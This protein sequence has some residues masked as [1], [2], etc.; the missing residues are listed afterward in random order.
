MNTLKA[1]LFTAITLLSYLSLSAQTEPS[2]GTMRQKA[3]AGKQKQVETS[4]VQSLPFESVGP[5]VF[6]GRVVDLD[7]SPDDPSHFLVAYASGGVW[8]TE[9]NGTSFSPL[10]DQEAV[11]TIGDIAADWSQGI[12]WV[13]TGEVNSSRSSYA[14]NGVYR[15][16][17]GGQTWHHLGL[18][19]SHHIGRIVLHPSDTNTAW[20]AVLGH[21]YSENAERGVYKT[22]DGG[23]TW[24][25][26]L[27]TDARTGAVDLVADPSNPDLIYAA[28]W[29]RSRRAWNFEEAGPGSGIWRSDD[30][31]ETWNRLT[32]AGSGFPHHDQVG[33]IG[34]ACYNG[35]GGQRLYAVVDNYERRPSKEGEQ[36]EDDKLTKDDLRAMTDEAFLA[37]DTDR[38]DDF[39]SSNG[40]PETYDAEGVRKMVRN[41]TI[42][43]LALVE[44]LED[45]NSLLFDTPIFGAQV[46]RSDDSGT[47]WTLTNEAPLEG[48]FYTYGY[49]F[50]QI[51]I[52]PSNPDKV[53]IMG[54]PVLKSED[55]GSTFSS[56]N[57]ANVH[58]DHHALWVNPNRPGHLI[59]GN[60][61]GVNISY[62]DGQHWVHCN[63]PPV[64]Q[65]YT[66]A[67]DMAEPFNIYGGLQD[68]GVWKGPSTYKASARWQSEGHYPYTRLMGGDGMQVAIDT[69][70]NETVYTGYQFGNT[71]RINA[72]G[73]GRSVRITPVHTLG[74]RPLRWNWQTPI[75]LSIHNQDILYLGSQ[76]VHRSMDQGNTFTAISQDLTGGGKKGD[77]PFGTLTT[78]HES[79]LQFGLIYT[80]SDDGLI[81]LTEDGGANWHR[82]TGPWPEGLWVSRVQA[83][84]HLQDRL[85]VALNGYRQDDF[86]AWLYMSEDRGAT[87]IDLGKSLPAEPVNV[88]R[89]DPVN[90]DLLY[91]GTDHGA[92]VSLNGGKDFMPFAGGLPNVPVH[93]L[94][95]HPRDNKLVLATHGRSFY[96][97]DVTH[98]QRLDSAMIQKPVATFEIAETRYNASWGA[99]RF[100]WSSFQQPTLEIPFYVQRAGEV[101]IEVSPGAIDGRQTVIFSDTI[102]ASPGLQTYDYSLTISESGV[103]SFRKILKQTSG[104]ADLPD[105]SL[106][107]DGRVYLVPGEYVVT[108]RS[109]GGE[110]R[111]QFV[112]QP[113]RERRR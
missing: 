68:N 10:F 83:S 80:G 42:Q 72:N 55:G 9:N 93:D 7:V 109:G 38:I 51:R 52:S 97:A 104:G 3:H 8:K 21:L 98:L 75:H 47:T 95:V 41:G 100:D 85:F 13:G 69:R 48:V 57:G 4:L 16:S 31:G 54:V 61:G 111:Q 5:S 44:Y 26:V 112:I 67:L 25:R 96:M 15:S 46:Y 107:D 33:R 88:V 65:F 86:E 40:F 73:R 103:G 90:P 74:E 71:F 49:Y 78:I 22:S 56:I 28:M 91:V 29:E 79:P 94:M 30:G 105:L 45:A 11:I 77:V 12:I 82:L 64:G 76:K 19:E 59:L 23:Q 92:W 1:S 66:V 81:H 62:D 39:L 24:R 99:R 70:D 6:G 35:E 58:A 2:P 108:V 50:G 63:T 17:D 60:D 101:I 113:P 53:Y 84:Q 36:Q 102:S 89:E 110:S 14:G 87:W 37:L 18:S 32:I 43:P 27:F 34:L 20:V 106:A